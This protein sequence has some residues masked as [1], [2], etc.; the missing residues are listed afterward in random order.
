MSLCLSM[1]GQDDVPQV[2]SVLLG[3][4]ALSAADLLK[5]FFSANSPSKAFSDA[6]LALRHR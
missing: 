1:S 5:L 6:I 3:S 4:N 2:D